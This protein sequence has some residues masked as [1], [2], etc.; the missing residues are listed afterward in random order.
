MSFIPSVPNPMFRTKPKTFFFLLSYFEAEKNERC[1][2]V[3][4]DLETMQAY[5]EHSHKH[6]D[7]YSS[8]QVLVPLLE[9]ERAHYV[10]SK[11]KQKRVVRKNNGQFVL[12]AQWRRI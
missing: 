6:R 9:N 7:S 2:L 10:R 3:F 4:D 5:E 12:N 8:P 1:I 11:V